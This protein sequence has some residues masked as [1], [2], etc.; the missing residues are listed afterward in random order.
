MSRGK[1]SPGFS[2]RLRLRDRLRTRCFRFRGA[3]T[4]V[5]NVPR[6]LP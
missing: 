6:L 1:A 3:L 4:R 5:P 2:L